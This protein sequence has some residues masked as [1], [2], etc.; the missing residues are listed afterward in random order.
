MGG[1]NAEV[2]RMI[3]R[4]LKVSFNPRQISLPL[5]PQMAVAPDPSFLPLRNGNP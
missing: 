2:R 4:R 1:Q 3:A 5:P